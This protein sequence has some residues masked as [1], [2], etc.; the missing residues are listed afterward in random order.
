[1]VSCKKFFVPLKTVKIVSLLTFD[2]LRDSLATVPDDKIIKSK[3]QK[4]YG[5]K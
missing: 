1:M 4:R 3:F 5:E 2:E